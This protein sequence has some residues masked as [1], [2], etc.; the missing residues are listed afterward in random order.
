MAQAQPGLLD[1]DPEEPPKNSP[2]LDPAVKAG[3]FPSQRIA[4][5]IQQGM[6]AG[7]EK[8]DEGQIQ[9]AS[10]DLR[11]GRW[12]YRIRA[13]FLPGQARTVRDQLE[14]FNAERIDLS[15]GAVLEKDC[16]YLVE[17]L[18]HLDLQQPTISGIANPKSS[19][20][21]LDIFTR[22]IADG[23][24]RFDTIS[25]NYKGPLY[26]EVSPRSFSVKVRT[27]SRL[28]QIRFRRRTSGQVEYSK[29]HFLSD[30]DLLARHKSSPLVDNDIVV[31]DGLVLSLA[32]SLSDSPE[33]IIGYKAQKYTG[34]IDVDNVDAYEWQDFWEPIYK[35][36]D[37]QL[38]LDPGGFYILASKEQLHIPPDLAAEM[39]PAEP[40]MG[41]F[42]VHYAGFFDPGFGF[43]LSGG[44]GAR[45][46][47]EVR[48][49]EVAFIL[50]HGQ[51]V[52]RLVYERMTEPSASTYGQV[53]G[54]NYQAQGLKLSKHFKSFKP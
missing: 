34:I 44:R 45:A 37:H 30:K 41:E 14:S 54:S 16:V 5:M 3:L 25:R 35:R 23:A 18:E 52:A 29:T 32:L 8:L 1:F 51:M 11:L 27:G 19:T 53:S 47:L 13:S 4:W 22:V 12:A 42:R 9:P 15:K 10:L 17:L 24:D 6:I 26:A 49:R 50:E 46:V 38:I 43:G 20:G 48:S 21:R 31:R 2:A 33:E 36:R 40:Q 7:L 28:N 39:V